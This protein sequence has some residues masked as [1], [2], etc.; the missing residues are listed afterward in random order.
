[1]KNRNLATAGLTT[2]LVTIWTLSYNW[3]GR[4]CCSSLVVPLTIQNGVVPVPISQDNFIFDRNAATPTVS[5]SLQS[6][7]SAAALFLENNPDKILLVAGKRGEA[8]TDP[9]LSLERANAV[10]DALV[11]AGVPAEQ[12]MIADSAESK[13]VFFQNDQTSTAA[14]LA[15]LSLE[16]LDVSDGDLSADANGNLRFARNV[17]TYEEPLDDA[18]RTELQKIADHLAANPDRT[19]TLTGRYQEAETNDSPFPNLGIARANAVKNLLVEMGAPANQF[20]LRGETDDDLLYLDD[21]LTGGI[22]YAFSETADNTDRLAA[23]R[24]RWSGDPLT[25][26]FE[27]N[28]QSLDFSGEQRS[29]LADL[30]YYLDQVPG[31]RV[32]ISGHTD[33]R[34]TESLNRRLSRKRAEFV[35]DYLVEN[36]LPQNRIAATGRA[37]E[38]PIATNETAEGRSLNRRVEVRLRE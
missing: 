22:G 19:L 34:G 17:D 8:E 26:Y 12:V 20:D 15:A 30:V 36:G 9:A 4:I 14:T 27:T 1:M 37:W 25:V 31:A 38:Q 18:V 6:S 10:R 3:Y 2:L 24:T 32:D 29:L 7:L 21:V 28:E 16:Y 5:E 11:A 33:D 23:I 13:M 35:R